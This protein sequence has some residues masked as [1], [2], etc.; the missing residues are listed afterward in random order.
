MVTNA[1]C[2]RRRE[3]EPTV[4]EGPG[5]A[6]GNQRWQQ[7]G[8]GLD[9]WQGNAEVGRREAE[10]FKANCERG[11]RRPTWWRGRV[12]GQSTSFEN[13]ARKLTLGREKGTRED[14][15]RV[16]RSD[17]TG[18][19]SVP[20][21]QLSC[22]CVIWCKSV[23]KKWETVFNGNFLDA[24]IWAELWWLE[25]WRN[26]RQLFEFVCSPMHG[27]FSEE[28]IARECLSTL[29][30]FVCS[31]MHGAFS[32]ENI[33]RECLSTLPYTRSGSVLRFGCAMVG[34]DR[35]LRGQRESGVQFVNHGHVDEWMIGIESRFGQWQKWPAETDSDADD[36]HNVA[37]VMLCPLHTMRAV[38]SS[39]RTCKQN[40]LVT[41][42]W[43]VTLRWMCSFCVQN[44]HAKENR[45]SQVV[46]RKD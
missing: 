15:K 2:Q 42:L 35:V 34:G 24:E 28:N 38:R 9:H 4:L 27:A 39:W 1:P 7:D 37:N 36:E 26:G 10:T 13:T 22:L 21:W 12:T 23:R 41:W 20:G 3:L 6:G 32:E 46:R 19:L 29:F 43:R 40:N 16:V 30:E 25:V 44:E 14:A 45:C 31:P 8:G 17:A 11:E 5:K 18:I 33:A